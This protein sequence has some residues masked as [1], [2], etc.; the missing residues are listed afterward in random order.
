MRSIKTYTILLALIVYSFTAWSQ[1]PV[2][3]IININ[4]SFYDDKDIAIEVTSK[5][6]IDDLTVP[7]KE[8]KTTIYKI[9]GNYLYKTANFES[10]AN[11]YYKINVNHQKKNII[12]AS[13]SNKAPQN[14]KTT[15]DELEKP[16]FKMSLDTILSYYKKVEIKNMDE[17][18]NE[19]IF[20]FKSGMYD[21]IKINYD[22]KSYLVY[23][24]FMKLNATMENSKDGK[25]HSYSYKITNRY[26]DKNM[27]SKK[28]FSE[29]NYVIINKQEIIPSQ[30]LNGYKVVN[31]TKD[32]NTKK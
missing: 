12:I 29:S 23:S 22:K 16:A 5:S 18:K 17:A 14:K 15:S 30:L 7:S 9:A 11:K 27:L 20:Y 4:K 25:K 28:L 6:F 3:E 1:D 13:V 2:R 31:N 8:S 26:L 21:Y 32:N 10:M 24:Y 19:I